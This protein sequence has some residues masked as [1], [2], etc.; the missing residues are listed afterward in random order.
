MSGPS[1]PK[2]GSDRALLADVAQPEETI[3]ESVLLELKESLPQLSIKTYTRLEENR[4]TGADWLWW[5]RGET[6]WFGGLVQAKKL[7]RKR[8]GT[9]H[10]EIGYRPKPRAGTAQPSPD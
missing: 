2:T 9:P 4:D 7:K 1:G 5:W 8:G 10:Y 6:A 3:T